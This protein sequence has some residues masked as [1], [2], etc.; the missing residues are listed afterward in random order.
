MYGSPRAV[1]LS[2]IRG[3]F[4]FAY[5]H[6]YCKPWFPSTISKIQKRWTS[7][8]WVCRNLSILKVQISNVATA[9][10]SCKEYGIF[11]FFNNRVWLNGTFANMLLA[12]TNKSVKKKIFYSS[13]FWS[14][15]LTSLLIFH[16]IPLNSAEPVVPDHF[17]EN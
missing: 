10:T 13:V 3:M 8:Y 2:S 11:P 4:K 14:L 17:T 9:K 5:P 12:G 16:F 6:N 1:E 15:P 7:S